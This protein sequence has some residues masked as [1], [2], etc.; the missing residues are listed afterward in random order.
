MRLKTNIATSENGFIF[1]PTTGD[2]FT[3]NTIAA[4]ILTYMKAGTSAEEIKQ[5][6]LDKYEVEP[7]QLERDWD[8]YMQQLKEAN[9]LEF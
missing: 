8:D 5:N 3:S 4:E 9:L 6:I 2:S 1:N 7:C